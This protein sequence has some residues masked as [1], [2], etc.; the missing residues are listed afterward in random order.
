MTTTLCCPS[1]EQILTPLVGKKTHD[2]C[3][4]LKGALGPA[5]YLNR[6]R[7]EDADPL[8]GAQDKVKSTGCEML[9]AA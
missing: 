4:T 1:A 2:G 5:A 6:P 8:P 3:A 7:G 9:A